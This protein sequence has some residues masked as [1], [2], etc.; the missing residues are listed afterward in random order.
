MLP[1][2]FLLAAV[3]GICVASFIQFSHFGRFIA[4]KLTW[5][6]VALGTG[7]DL[8]IMLLLLDEGGRVAWWQ[9]VAILFF[10]S[11]AIAAR[12]LYQLATYYRGIMD[13][14]RDTDSE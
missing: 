3:W 2:A 10:S 12:S 6:I 1:F 13:G 7:G 8:L 4:A 9:V 11:I 5:F 14:A